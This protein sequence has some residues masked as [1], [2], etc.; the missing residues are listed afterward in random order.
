MLMTMD[1]NEVRSELEPWNVKCDHQRLW[2][3]ACRLSACRDT[4]RNRRSV[5]QR[6]HWC[7]RCCACCPAC[8]CTR[9]SSFR[10][11]N[12]VFTHLFS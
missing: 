11:D 9:H 8:W 10:C 7:S 4:P 2:K 3:D 6:R 1:G 5:R 12:V